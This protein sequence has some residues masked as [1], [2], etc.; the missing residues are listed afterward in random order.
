MAKA[1]KEGKRY[2]FTTKKFCKDMKE[3]PNDWVKECNGREVKI[4][5]SDSGVIGHYDIN[6]HW[7]KEIS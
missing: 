3:K 7:C 1:F 6:P 4:V 5:N 2:V